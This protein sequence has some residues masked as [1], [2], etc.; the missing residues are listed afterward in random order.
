MREGFVFYAMWNGEQM[1]DLFEALALV[2]S[3]DSFTGLAQCAVLLGFLFVMLFGAVRHQGKP[4]IAYFACAVLFWWIA[5]VPRVTVVVQDVRS[6]SVYP[7]D[8]VPLAIGVFGSWTSQIGHFLTETYETAFT[9]ITAMHYSRFGA[10]YP[11]RI[12]T[13]LQAVGPVTPTAQA[14][15]KAVTTGCI[16]PEM[17]SDPRK[18]AQITASADL[19]G[20]ISQAGWVNPARMTP[21]PLGVT[22]CPQA[23]TDFA[24]VLETEELP[25]LQR[26]LGARWAPGDADPGATLSTAVMESESLLLGLSRTMDESLRHSLLLTAIPQA[27]QETAA[28]GNAPLAA[29]VGLAKAQGSLAAELNYRTMAKIAEE[30]LPKFRNALEFLLLAMFPV[31]ALL[32]LSAGQSMGVLLRTYFVLLFSVELW[33]ALASVI[34]YLHISVDAHPFTALTQAF[35]GNSLQA[36]A[37]IRETGTAAQSVSGWLMISVPFIAFAIVKGGDIAL[38]HLTSG[39]TAPAAS[40]ASAQGTSLAAGNV[41]QGSANLGNVTRHNVSANKMDASMRTADAGMLSTHSAYGSVTRDSTGEVTAASRTGIDLGVS[42]SVSQSWSRAHN[43]T[44]GTRSSFGW[45]QAANF[46]VAQSAASGNKTQESF[47]QALTEAI[48]ASQSAQTSHSMQ[49]GTATARGVSSAAAVSTSEEM[50]EG[51]FLT[52]GAGVGA[53]T[54][55]IPNPVALTAGRPND[56]IV[57]GTWRRADPLLSSPHTDATLGNGALL[58]A[59]A[60][61]NKQSNAVNGPSLPVK[62]QAGIDLRN[63]EAQS[64]IDQATGKTETRSDAQ[65]REAYQRVQ[66][67][68]EQVANTHSDAS[69][70]RAARE[71]SA[72]LSDAASANLDRRTTN[73]TERAAASTLQEDRQAGLQTAVNHDIALLKQAIARFGSPE[74][75]L[76]SLHA[77]E[78]R[79]TLAGGNYAQQRQAAHPHDTFGPGAMESAIVRNAELRGQGERNVQAAH[80]ENLGKIAAIGAP[81]TPAQLVEPSAQSETQ[82]QQLLQERELIRSESEQQLTRGENDLDLTRG[83]LLVAREAWRTNNTD[84][85]YSTWKNAFLGGLDYTTGD[86]LHQGLLTK[87]QENPALAQALMSIGTQGKSALSERDWQRLVHTARDPETMGKFVPHQQT[88]QE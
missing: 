77:A 84:S 72:S 6:Q 30:S 67:A 85:T 44:H 71:F 49:Q 10:V 31:V 56:D 53:G 21:T 86:D 9:P 8:N 61:P 42:S 13:A 78:N 17:L 63:M 82:R 79:Q 81:P 58:P 57:E 12:V 46:S 32:A 7:V 76:R 15:M 24:R 40:A 39:L 73:G 62:V 48:S 1:R 41:T 25:A 38:T 35:G 75:A 51:Q 26:I 36:A 16:L 18:A 4:A 87:A 27:V 80:Q 54:G 64:L 47:A 5:M 69:V 11:Q 34:N 23:L 65:A 45:T 88:S 70:R 68:A 37:L 19:W 29:A 2:T 22:Y 66:Q 43:V 33:P 55:R 59:H 74:E 3:L 50:R 28:Q 83:A 20:L 60:M 52:T 14:Q